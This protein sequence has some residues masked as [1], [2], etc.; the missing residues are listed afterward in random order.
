MKY[1]EPEM[2][3]IFIMD[4]AEILTVS[5][6]ENESGDDSVDYPFGNMGIGE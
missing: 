6:V 1:E 3:V 2:T 4:D 5:G